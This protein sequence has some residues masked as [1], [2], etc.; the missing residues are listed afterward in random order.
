MSYALVTGGGTDGLYT[1]ELDWGAAQKAALLAALS[2]IQ[3]A[4]ETKIELQQIVVD[5]HDAN[6][7]AAAQ[8]LAEVVDFFMSQT[9]EEQA[10]GGTAFFKLY[11]FLYQKALKL[12]QASIPARLALQTLKQKQTQVY[13][14]IAYWNNFVAIESRSA[15]C[16]DF[17]EDATG[18]VGIVSINGESE[19][20]LIFPGGDTPVLAVDGLLSARELMSPE[21]AYFNAAIL[22]GWQKDKPTYR[23]GTITSLDYNASTATIELDDATSS[24][25][26]LNINWE[27]TFTNVPV[28]YMTCHAVAFNNGDKAVVDFNLSQTTGG[29]YPKIIGFVDHPKQC[30]LYLAGSASIG[31]GLIA[32]ES[33]VGQNLFFFIPSAAAAANFTLILANASAVVV[34]GRI[35]KGAWQS[36][37]RTTPPAVGEAWRLGGVSSNMLIDFSTGSIVFPF[38]RSIRV[39]IHDRYQAFAVG[40]V[41]EVRMTLFGNVEFNVAYEWHGIPPGGTPD[42]GGFYYGETVRM[43]SRG[44]VNLTY[45]SDP[46]NTYIEQLNYVLFSEE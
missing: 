15:W 45:D 24:A 46:P 10:A 12:Q 40:D 18:F 36:Y 39:L 13:K 31:E 20:L 11:T 21:Q 27:T 34:E 35:N 41:W 4:N 33:S 1:I 6:E 16:V 2:T 32:G 5:Q 3:V 25:Q 37:E 9:P 30:G 8:Q 38:N 7:A 44:G 17:T 23:T 14:Q 28:E 42:G 29:G 22:P 26:G 43:R 19:T